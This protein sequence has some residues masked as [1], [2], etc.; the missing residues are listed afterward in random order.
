MKTI[1]KY[2][3]LLLFTINEKAKESIRSRK[4]CKE[5]EFDHYSFYTGLY[6]AYSEIYT[7]ISQDKK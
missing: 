7:M 1:K 3:N 5:T 6:M 2:Q 4:L